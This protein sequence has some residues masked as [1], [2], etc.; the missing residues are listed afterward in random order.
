MGLWLWGAPAPPGEPPPSEQ[1]AASTTTTHVMRPRFVGRPHATDPGAEQRD[2]VAHQLGLRPW[3]RGY[4]YVGGPDE[5]FEAVILPDGR[6][7]FSVDPSVKIAFDG[8]C[9][10]AVC[11]QTKAG[12]EHERRRKAVRTGLTIA[13]LVAEAALG[14]VTLGAVRQAYGKPINGP[15]PELRDGFPAFLLASTM[16]RYGHLPAPTGAM[17]E[18][19]ERT[20]DLRLEMAVEEARREL[21]A[22]DQ[23]LAHELVALWRDPSLSDAQ[24]RAEILRRW[25]DIDVEP[26]VAE[27]APAAVAPSVSAQPAPAAPR[28]PGDTVLGEALE[29]PL[30]Q[31]RRDAATRARHKIVDSVRLHAPEGSAAGFS[32]AQLETFNVGRPAAARFEPY[33]PEPEPEPEPKP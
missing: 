3:G 15:S 10:V 24:R 4:R 32:P 17:A 5:R 20:F 13:A 22:A 2:A 27:P 23:R 6:V 28:A 30:A 29:G 18:L 8:I 19:M 16:G 25:Q 26:V 12:R 31:V 1:A 21:E 9:V 11:K 7:E 33:P 14:R